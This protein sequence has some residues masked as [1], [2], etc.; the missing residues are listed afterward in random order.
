VHQG[1]YVKELVD[2]F[3]TTESVSRP[4][5]IS[6]GV[7]M[8]KEGEAVSDEVPFG[9][10]VGAL[11]YLATCTRPDIAD[12]VGQSSRY[13]AAPTV[14]HWTIAK[15]VLRYLKRNP[16]RGLLFGSD[17]VVCG[18]ADANFAGC[19]D[20]RRSTTGFVFLMHDSVVALGSRIQPTVA[21][22]TCEAEYMAVGT[23]I[24]EALCLRKLLADLGY[25]VGI[26]EIK[27][28]NQAAL[29]LLENPLNMSQSKHID[30]VHH[31]ARER[32]ERGDVFFLVCPTQQNIADGLTKALGKVMFDAYVARMGCV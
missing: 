1:L 3:K 11:M 17:N 9:P 15:G 20:T 13:M 32:I 28:D 10:V 4:A 24:R 30:V 21:T 31:F 6:P 29:K 18:Y 19:V 23:T 16:E 26:M 22:S 7:T 27:G 12:V 25:P 5:P 14:K 8:T 2:Q